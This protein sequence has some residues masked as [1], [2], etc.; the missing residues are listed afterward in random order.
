MLNSK[1][2]QIIT[3]VLQLMR[4]F[5]LQVKRPSSIQFL[6]NSILLQEE[7]NNTQTCYDRLR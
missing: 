3:S 4:H 5:L 1:C 6:T 2:L 7:I